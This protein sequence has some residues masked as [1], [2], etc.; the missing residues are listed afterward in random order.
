M[1]AVGAHMKPLFNLL[2]MS[3]GLPSLPTWPPMNHSPPLSSQRPAFDI[4]EYLRA[5]TPKLV[6][7]L[8]E[9]YGS[10]SLRRD[11]LAGLRTTA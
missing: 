1:T 5:F 11:A 4:V 10:D 8:R 2:G 3:L 6:T 9:G 7:A